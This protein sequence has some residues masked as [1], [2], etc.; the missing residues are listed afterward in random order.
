MDTLGAVNDSLSHAFF[1]GRG[2]YRGIRLYSSYLLVALVL[3]SSLLRL[4]CPAPPA[5]LGLQPQLSMR[6]FFQRPCF[7]QT[8]SP[9][10]FLYVAGNV[11]C[12]GFRRYWYRE[13]LR[14]VD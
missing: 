11:W 1:R 9:I 14:T 2:F 4:Y 5:H 10:H 3:S 13:Q 6:L 8:I 12:R 7:S